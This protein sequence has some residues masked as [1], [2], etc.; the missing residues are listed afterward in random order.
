MIVS[1]A[2]WNAASN[3]SMRIGT[4]KI[5]LRVTGVGNFFVGMSKIRII[6]KFM[7]KTRAYAVDWKMALIGWEK[8]YLIFGD[9]SFSK[10]IK[11]LEEIFDSHL[12]RVNFRSDIF[13]D[14]I[15]DW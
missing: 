9:P 15:L 7:L 8:N 11:V 13:L 10:F 2:R 12:S 14:V 3:D 1:S 5:L 6:Q 4:R